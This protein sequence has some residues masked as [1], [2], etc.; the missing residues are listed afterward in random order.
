MKYQELMETLLREKK[1]LNEKGADLLGMDT[2]LY[3]ISKI[4]EDLTISDIKKT[5][6]NNRGA[7]NET[8]SVSYGYAALDKKQIEK[9]T[10]I[11]EFIRLGYDGIGFHILLK[12]N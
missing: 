10:K 12:S 11:P 3:K 4:S 1:L 8:V 2:V 9:L 6:Y 7:S 5:E